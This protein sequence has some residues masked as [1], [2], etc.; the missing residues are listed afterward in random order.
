[1]VLK[2]STLQSRIILIQ[3]NDS[4]LHIR[5]ELDYT[6]SIPHQN[7]LIIAIVLII[8]GA[9]LYYWVDIPV[10]PTTV[11]T[12]IIVLGV[13]ALVVWFILVLIAAIKNA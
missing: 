11:G 6:M 4:F 5:N 10:G 8:V 9:V 7:L 12:I 2:L 3:L 1:V 13:I